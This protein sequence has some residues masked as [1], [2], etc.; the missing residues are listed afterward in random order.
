MPKKSRKALLRRK[1]RRNPSPE[2]LE[3]NG[4]LWL[5]SCHRLRC[6]WH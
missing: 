4:F 6:N 2:D 1:D 3:D 5:E